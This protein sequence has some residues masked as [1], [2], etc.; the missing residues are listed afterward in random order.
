MVVRLK[1]RDVRIEIT[2]FKGIFVILKKIYLFEL[3]SAVKPVL[4]LIMLRDQQWSFFALRGAIIC[5]ISE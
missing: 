4:P 2:S 5:L 3:T 1:S